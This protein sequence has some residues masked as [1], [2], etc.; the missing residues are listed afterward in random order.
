MKKIL[1][2]PA[3]LILLLA[4]VL[5]LTSCGSTS[6]GSSSSGSSSSEDDGGR[7]KVVAT[8]FAAYDFARQVSGGNAD[9]TMLIKPGTDVHSYDPTVKD[10]EEIENCD[11]F[12]YAGGENDAWVD[13]ILDSLDN[14]PKTVVMTECT[15]L[16]KEEITG[17]MQTTAEQRS[18]DEWDEHVW[19]S[20]MNAQKIA[21]AISDSLQEIDPEHASDYEKNNEEYQKELQDLDS[22]FRDV[23]NNSKR[24]TVIFADR[25]P[26]RYFTEEYG[27]TYYAAYPGCASDAEPSAKTVVSL[28]ERVKKENIPAVF[29]IELS[30]QKMADTVAEET[31]AK[32][33]LF[34]SCHNVTAQ[35]FEDGV[36]YISLMRDNLENLRYALN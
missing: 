32:K 31:G 9:V 25:F 27:L 22:D 13:K 14:K 30:N 11:L 26:V 16:Y 4:A 29:Y 17:G 2:L 12:I 20:P 34:S 7:V 8:I 18:E 21:S 19:T 15:G 23:V 10:I 24:K 35:Q 33:L 3:L 5:V 36:T 6:S 28:I 1:R